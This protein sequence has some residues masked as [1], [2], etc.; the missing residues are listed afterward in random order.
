VKKMFVEKWGWSTDGV[1]GGRRVMLENREW[2]N[3]LLVRDGRRGRWQEFNG[4]S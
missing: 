1:E 2:F 4:L 3:G